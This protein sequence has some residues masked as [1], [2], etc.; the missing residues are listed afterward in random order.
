MI[1]RTARVLGQQVIAGQPIG[2]QG[3]ADGL[4]GT[5]GDLHADNSVP[6]GVA[7]TVNKALVAAKL[8]EHLSHAAV[9]EIALMGALSEA[10]FNVRWGAGG[11]AFFLPL[12]LRG[13]YYYQLPLRGSEWTLT[14]ET[15]Q[16]F[17][18]GVRVAAA[19]SLGELGDAPPL[20]IWTGAIAPA[21][22]VNLNMVGG[23][24]WLAV[25]PECAGRLKVERSDNKPFSIIDPNTG[26]VVRAV[27]PGQVMEWLDI[28]PDSGGITLRNDDPGPDDA[29]FW[30]LAKLNT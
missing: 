29:T 3:A 11:G 18:Q 27:A 19:I 9:L 17:A 16:P 14:L 5:I 4:Q 20:R 12:T 23:A 28:D 8:P 1:N 24:G 15:L 7:L 21:G 30:V 26:L 2:M 13:P 22:S 6:A 10:R 25:V